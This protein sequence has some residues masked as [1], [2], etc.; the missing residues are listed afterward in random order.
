MTH[1]E[2]NHAGTSH[3]STGKYLEKSDLDPAKFKTQSLYAIADSGVTVPHPR[4]T[5]VKQ[6]LTSAKPYRT[7]TTNPVVIAP[8]TV[9]GW[10]VDFPDSGELSNIDMIL[11]Q[12]TLLVPTNVP[13]R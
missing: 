12:G 11:A 9:N 1:E 3:V 6:T 13:S 7:V 2:D 5:M 4:A 8:P 10:F